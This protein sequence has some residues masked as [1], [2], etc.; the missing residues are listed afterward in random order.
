MQKILT[1]IACFM[2][3]NSCS[4]FIPECSNE[5]VIYF[6]EKEIRRDMVS[7]KALQLLLEEQLPIYHTLS[8]SLKKSYQLGLNQVEKQIEK[9]AHDFIYISDYHN[10][11]TKAKSIITESKIDIH[12][13]FTIDIKYDLQQCHCK[14]NITSTILDDKFIK[15]VV[16]KKGARY[17]IDISYLEDE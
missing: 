14:A 3:F 2:T 9:D 11:V 15:Y 10:F 16:H 13:V 7:E 6:L 1:T 5:D 12:N 4:F 8:S 17:L